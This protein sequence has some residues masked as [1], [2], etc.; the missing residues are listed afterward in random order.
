M[1][2]IGVTV[3]LLVFMAMTFSVTAVFAS[4]DTFRCGLNVVAVGDSKYQVLAKCGKPSDKDVRREK[5]IKRDLYRDLFPP[6]GQGERER[7][8]EP[9]LVEEYVN[10]EE[11]TYDRG[12][13]SLI[14][15][16]TFENGKL[17]AVETDGYGN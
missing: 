4:E 6:P 10:I 5:R 14:T 9:F 17:V 7:Y 2:I 15:V 16:L 1:R 11:W 3:C 12:P 13:S 8:R